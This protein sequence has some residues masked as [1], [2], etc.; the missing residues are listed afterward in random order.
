MD[1]VWNDVVIPAE[2]PDH[3]ILQ[4]CHNTLD[5][6]I[7]VLSHRDINNQPRCGDILK[8]IQDIRELSRRVQGSQ[9]QGKT[10]WEGG[11]GSAH[12]QEGRRCVMDGQN[13]GDVVPRQQLLISCICQSEQTLSFCTFAPSDLHSVLTK[14]QH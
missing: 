3:W 1:K 4:T 12:L 11:G 9:G 8:L 7:D 13:V 10:R 2:R 6:G 14:D 5:Y